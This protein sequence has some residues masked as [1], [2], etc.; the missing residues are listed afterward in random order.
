MRPKRYLGE[1]GNRWTEVDRGLAEGLLVYEASLNEHGFPTWLAQ[2][3]EQRFA[4]DEYIDHAAA[5]HEDYMESARSSKTKLEPGTRIVV[6]HMGARA[7]PGAG[8][9]PGG[10][11]AQGA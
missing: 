3:G 8:K 1:K 9:S 7:T 5:A 10:E 6:K 2:D 4:P 11:G